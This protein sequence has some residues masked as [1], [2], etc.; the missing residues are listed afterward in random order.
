[1]RALIAAGFFREQLPAG[2]V[3]F[4]QGAEA[5]AR[6]DD[7]AAV[8]AFR[9]LA[10]RPG[11]LGQNLMPAVFDRAGELD[12]AERI[13]QRVADTTG[14]LNGVGLAHVRAARRALARGDRAR[15]EALARKIVDAW[16]GA[17]VPIPA[18]A[19]VRALSAAR[20]DSAAS[21]TQGAFTRS[22]HPR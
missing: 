19:E 11:S 7:A 13:D 2:Q 5:Y 9:Q 12:L 22:P 8:A 16:S 10:H 6:G 1:L 14:P 17:D 4:I 3:S 20:G 21:R 15:A 18:V